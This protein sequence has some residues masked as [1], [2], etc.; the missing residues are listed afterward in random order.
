M[1][2]SDRM[3]AADNVTGKKDVTCTSIFN[4]FDL[5]VQGLLA[6]SRPDH[7]EHPEFKRG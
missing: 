6:H 1:G 2:P 4:H 3:V 5:C 7:T